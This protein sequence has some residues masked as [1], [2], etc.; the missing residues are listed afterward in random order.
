MTFFGKGMNLYSNRMIFVALCSSYIVY[1]YIH[2]IIYIYRTTGGSLDFIV[3]GEETAQFEDE[4]ARVTQEL[5][6]HLGV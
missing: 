4:V 2:I 5:V 1:I 3:N 6:K